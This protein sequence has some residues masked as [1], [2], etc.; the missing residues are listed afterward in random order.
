M[1]VAFDIQPLLDDEK[2]WIGYCEAGFVRNIVLDHPETAFA[3]EYFSFKNADAKKKKAAIYLAQN[4][5]ISDCG[6]ITG[7][8]YRFLSS[9]FPLPY[10]WFFNSGADITHFFNAIIPPFVKGKKVVTIHDMVIRRFPESMNARTRFVLGLS[11]RKT[12]KRADMIITVSEFSKQEILKYYPCSAQKLKVIYQGIDLE[13]YHDGISREESRRV[14]GVYN[15]TDDYILYLG[16]LEPRKNIERLIE[17]YALLRNRQAAAPV[18]VIAGKKGWRFDGI[19]HQVKKLGLDDRVIFTGYI[20]DQDKSAL[21]A[22]AGFFCFPSLY[23]G[24]GLPPLEAMACGTPVLTSNAASLPESVGNAALLV[25]PYS[26]EN[27]AEAMERLCVDT[28]LR[29]S[30]REKGLEWVK[31]FDWNRLS[32]SLYSVYVS[33]AAS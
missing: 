23:E 13:L 17:A 21:L 15:I 29:E 31:R 20:P 11:L 33:L 24:F 32:E 3:L 4:A 19:F 6:K 12:I 14:C 18:L 2:T 26:V 16:T 10:R 30:L 25:N 27:I 28:A 8:V 5:E 7:R 1:K 22:G 9:L